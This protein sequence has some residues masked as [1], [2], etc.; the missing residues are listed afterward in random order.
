V[1][2][3]RERLIR[4]L[5]EDARVRPMDGVDVGRAQSNHRDDRGTSRILDEFCANTRWHRSHARKA[6]KAALQPK[7][8]TPRSPRP[9]KYGPD[10]T[11]ALMVRWT[12]PAMPAG[13]RLAPML[14]QPVAVLHQFGELVIDEATAAL[15]VSMSAATIDRRLAGE[16]AKHQLKGVW[17]QSRDRLSKARSRCAPRPSGTTRSPDSSRSTWSG[18]TAATGLEAMHLP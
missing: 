6:L 13:K 7:I 10:V 15:L 8:V 1:K 14:R 18:A 5:I 3:A 4:C 9:V 16:R 17:G 12:V 11:A 2:N